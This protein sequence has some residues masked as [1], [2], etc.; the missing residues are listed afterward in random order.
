[1]GAAVV[2]LWF[3]FRPL[4]N[5]VGIK[6][7]GAVV[8]FGLAT[9]VFGL[10][11]SMAIS[12]VALIALGAFDMLSVY[13]RSSLVQL[14]TPDDMRGRVSAVS[15]LAIS[16]SNE[17]GEVQSGLAAAALGPVGA[18]VFGGIAAM[19]I[20]V[21][22]AYLFPELRRARTFDPPDPVMQEKPV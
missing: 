18:V 11:K 8:G 2:A 6:M 1:M 19:G 15:G 5:N 22:W 20:A 21:G 13:V 16:S 3:A 12:L 7:L 10:S 9:V 17:L 4:Q 14:Y